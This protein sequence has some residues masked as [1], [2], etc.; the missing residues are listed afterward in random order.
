[1]PVQ[2]SL[3]QST[4]GG[5]G[6]VLRLV[7]LLGCAQVSR[8]GVTDR[9]RGTQLTGVCKVPQPGFC[10]LAD[11]VVVVEPVDAVGGRREARPSKGCGPL[12]AGGAAAHHGV[13]VP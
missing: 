11:G 5:E 6:I 13:A 8:G 4:F 2:L 7:R 10:K 1:M 9:G 3:G 12:G